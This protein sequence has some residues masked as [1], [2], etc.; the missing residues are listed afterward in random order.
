MTVSQER[1]DSEEKIYQEDETALQ[2]KQWESR[3][4]RRDIF[5]PDYIPN[6]RQ[7][8][9]C[10]DLMQS[11]GIEFELYDYDRSGNENRFGTMEEELNRRALSVLTGNAVLLKKGHI[12][13]DH[14]EYACELFS[15][16][17]E[18]QTREL[19]ILSNA[20]LVCKKLK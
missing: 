10:S 5:E 20:F 3:S 6:E 11:L 14:G 12:I 13:V 18:A 4:N 16:G 15:S 8:R 19:I 1:K 2:N 17:E 7:T 9:E